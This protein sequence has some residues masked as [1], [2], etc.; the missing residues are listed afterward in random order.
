MLLLKVLNSWRVRGPSS[1]VQSWN[2]W[3]ESTSDAEMSWDCSCLD[4]SSLLFPLWSLQDEQTL[5]PTKRELV[6]VQCLDKILVQFG[7]SLQEQRNIATPTPMKTHCRQ[8]HIWILRHWS[9][10]AVAKHLDGAS[11]DFGKP[12]VLCPKLIIQALGPKG[13][14]CAPHWCY[15]RHAD[16]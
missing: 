9:I 12:H 15:C 14:H 4:L 3:M 1:M 8:H 13:Q 11:S 7:T 2:H 10:P 5:I 6:Q 16:F